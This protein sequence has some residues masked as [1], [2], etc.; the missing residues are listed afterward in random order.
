MPSIRYKATMKVTGIV[1]DSSVTEM[2]KIAVIFE[3][4]V[5]CESNLLI[6]RPVAKD[7]R[8]NIAVKSGE[9]RYS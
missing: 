7:S 1:E 4:L 2:L 5:L 8:S 9:Q 3:I 6:S